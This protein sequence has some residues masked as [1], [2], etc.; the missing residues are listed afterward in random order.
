VTRPRDAYRRLR[1]RSLWLQLGVLAAGEVAIFAV[2][3]DADARFHWST[4]FLVGLTTAAVVNLL[5]LAIWSRPAPGQLGGILGW[6]L[7]AAAPDLVFRLGVPHYEWMD[8]FLGH[9]SVHEI[10]G[11]DETLLGVALATAGLYIASLTRW[12]R[13]RAADAAAG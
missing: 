8:V 1:P 4:H 13:A 5:V 11:G 7:L 9:I 6:H 12:L 3:A 10:V 2:Y